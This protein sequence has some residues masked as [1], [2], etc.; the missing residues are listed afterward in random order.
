MGLTD[1]KSFLEKFVQKVAQQLLETNRASP[2]GMSSLLCN[3]CGG[4]G[5]HGGILFLRQDA[6]V[7]GWALPGKDTRVGQNHQAVASWE[8]A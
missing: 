1:K 2:E 8:G 6:R 5:M 7:K 4:W 3:G